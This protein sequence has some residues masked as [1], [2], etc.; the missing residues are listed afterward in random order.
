MSREMSGVRFDSLVV[1]PAAVES[2]RG[3]VCPDVF[4]CV[5]AASLVSSLTK[6]FRGE[7]NFG[8][9]IFLFMR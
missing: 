8:R 9:R 4:G 7:M 6:G 2:G 3:A 5:N 1:V